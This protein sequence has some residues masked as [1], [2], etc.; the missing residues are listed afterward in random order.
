MKEFTQPHLSLTI[1]KSSKQSD[2]P[3]KW[4]FI[5]T[6]M[7]LLVT[8][9]SLYRLATETYRLQKLTE[10][11]SGFVESWPEIPTITATAT[12][13]GSSSSRWWFADTETASL[14]PS[15][16]VAH[17]S[18][19]TTEIVHKTTTDTPSTHLQHE[20]SSRADSVRETSVIPIT[21]QSLFDN[22]GL[23]PL[24]NIFIF[25]WSEQHTA[26]VKKALGKVVESMEFVW[27]ICRKVYHYPL[28][29]P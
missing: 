28:D 12:V 19:T 23:I 10:G 20:G 15:S 18:L 17:P 27:S 29:P 13:Y 25:S 3:V 9:A 7:L 8:F 21:S 5:L 14:S 22:F 26:A 4:Y 16:S 2:T 1:R 6:W 24:D 11:Y